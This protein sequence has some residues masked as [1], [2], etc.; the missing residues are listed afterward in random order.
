MKN[1][2]V[3]SEM[4]DV[5]YV[6]LCSCSSFALDEEAIHKTIAMTF[7]LFFSHLPSKASSI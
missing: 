2:R 5:Q 3:G 4:G 7:L 6:S 1:F